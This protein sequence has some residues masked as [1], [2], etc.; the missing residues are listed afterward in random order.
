MSERKA[1]ARAWSA[2]RFA[3]LRWHYPAGTPVNKI[4]LLVNAEAGPAIT[5]KAVSQCAVR[6]GISR[7][8]SVYHGIHITMAR[9]IS[10]SI[11]DAIDA[12]A[13]AKKRGISTTG[14]PRDVAARIA[15]AVRVAA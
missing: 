6:A 11:R 15:D 8:N 9:C 1:P 13:W 2:A 14:A 10:I 4:A 12:L 3:I 5:K 7:D